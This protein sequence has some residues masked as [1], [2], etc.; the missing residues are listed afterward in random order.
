[1]EMRFVDGV[2]DIAVTGPIVR[3]EFFLLKG[4]T[5]RDHEDENLDVQRV[6]SFSIAMPLDAFANSVS[7]FENVRKKLVENRVLGQVPL[8]DDQRGSPA[9]KTIHSPNFGQKIS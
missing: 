2:L 5:A 9:P 8:A 7:I 3:I 1:M 6:P 4:S